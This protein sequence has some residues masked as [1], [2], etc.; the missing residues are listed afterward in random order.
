MSNSVFSSIC[1]KPATARFRALI[2]LILL[3]SLA[4]T[5]LT[6][7]DDAEAIVTKNGEVWPPKLGE[8]YPNLE[9]STITVRNGI[10]RNLKER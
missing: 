5:M 3:L 2:S 4:S 10:L 1:A 6:G 9:V 7:C 8:S